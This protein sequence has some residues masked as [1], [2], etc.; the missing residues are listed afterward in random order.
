MTHICDSLDKS[1]PCTINTVNA[2]YTHRNNGGS[3]VAL[4]R[5]IDIQCICVYTVFLAGKS[6]NIRS[7]TMYGSISKERCGS[8][9][10]VPWI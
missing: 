4:A 2:I 6:P 9:H 8:K 1:N 10:T 5:A 7:Y 3:N